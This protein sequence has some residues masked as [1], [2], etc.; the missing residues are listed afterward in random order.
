MFIDAYGN[1]GSATAVVNRIDKTAPV[2]T[3][4]SYSPATNTN[5][6]VTVTLVTSEAV[7]NIS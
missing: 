2:A 1:T 5:Q 6:P 7:Q 4:V 3:N